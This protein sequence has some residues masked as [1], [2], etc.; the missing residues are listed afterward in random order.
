MA[1]GFQVNT[2]ITRPD[3][4]L[5]ERFAPLHSA[6]ICDAMNKA[7]AVSG[8]IRPLYS[9]MR[10][11]VGPAVTVSAPTGALNVIK[12]GM[13]QTRRGDVLVINGYGNTA[14]AFIGGNLCRGLLKR[15]LAGIL[16]D[17][18]ARDASEISADGLPVYSRGVAS[19]SGPVDGPGEVNV[20]V[21]C[22]G[23][24]V[25]PGDIVVA[26]SDGVMVVPPSDADEVLQAVAKIQ[27]WQQSLQEILL[28]GEVT[29]IAA[30]EQK[31][32]EQGCEFR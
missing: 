28:R 21:A 22:G 16:I 11:V 7:G 19:G 14:Y 26:D 32:R 12:E 17:G 24:V 2:S 20:P 10:K 18:A 6:D 31:L 27:T 4:G 1:V 15:G 30:I 3:P 25:N 8:A 29:N 23:V 9:P 13:Q 5:L